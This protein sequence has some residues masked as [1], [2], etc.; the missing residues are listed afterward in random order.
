QSVPSGPQPFAL[1]ASAGFGD[2]ADLSLG[3]TKSDPTP[4]VGEAFDFVVT[5]TNDGPADAP[6]ATVVDTLPTGMTYGTAVPS[7]GSCG[8]VVATLTCNLGAIAD[9]AQA[10][11][12]IP[13]TPTAT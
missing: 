6:G 1:V 2:L 3:M 7:Q 12:T 13:V 11:V 8:L 10:T 4:L 5:V 9:G